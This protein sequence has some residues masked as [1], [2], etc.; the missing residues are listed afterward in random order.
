LTGIGKSF[1]K[2]GGIGIM[3]TIAKKGGKKKKDYSF[4]FLNRFMLVQLVLILALC[5]F[6]TNAISKRAKDSAKLHLQT[7]GVQRA[8]VVENYVANAE[9]TLHSF[10][11]APQI[12]EL[13][14][15]TNEKER[16]ELTQIVQDYTSAFAEGLEGLEGLY[17]C[18]WNSKTLTHSSLK[19][20]GVV[21]REGD[22]LEG[23]RSSIMDA[24]KEIFNAGL[25]VSPNSGTSV[26]SMYQGIY[27]DD[28]NPVGFA[29]FA[30]NTNNLRDKLNS[31][32]TLGWSSA[33]YS[34]ID[35]TQKVYVFDEDDEKLAGSEIV[36]PDLLRT[37]EEVRGVEEVVTDVY[38]FK[39]GPLDAV[40]TY[41]YMPNRQWILMMNANRRE[42]YNLVNA[43]IMF[44]VTFTALMVAMLTLF[45]YLNRKQERVNERLLSSIEK[46]K[47]T[48]H[49]LTSA[50]Y[51]D[52]LT[53]V[54]NRIRFSMDIDNISDSQT[55]P[56]YF[57]LFNIIDFSSIN[58][59]F[60][61]DTGDTL[62][63]RTADI[64]KEKFDA[65]TIYRTGSDEFVVVI[66]TE[67]GIPRQEFILDDVNET[68]RK[69]VLPEDVP[70]VGTIYPKYRVA[71]VKKSSDID[72]S[73]I[74]V[75]KEMTKMKGEAMLG[76]ID[77][78]DLSDPTV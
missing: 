77:F 12:R 33:F 41:Y 24:G 29:G 3:A 54:G 2:K 34:M 18:D 14:M 67:N 35:C 19:T 63:V 25:L 66:K 65:T 45:T 71:V 47:E 38:E 78:S 11:K 13:L 49:S 16:K 73:V 7:L 76:M 52:V 64:L 10:A 21:I 60:G 22:S 53:D 36:L 61:N 5:L 1:W 62:L 26:I 15:C 59:S 70:G 69:L 57:A 30:I 37:I 72:T 32:E 8:E 48:K 23:L 17:V 50:M 42:V 28:G 46:I 68:L 39:M 27:D 43:M 51:N 55:N 56:Y 6:I 4:K 20:V 74:T 40:G 31:L 58:T 44:M 9:S 75:M